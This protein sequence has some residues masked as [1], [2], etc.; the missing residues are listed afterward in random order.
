MGTTGQ[1]RSSIREES[2]TA[3]HGTTL[4]NIWVRATTPTISCGTHEG[5]TREP[6]R[7]DREA[8]TG[9]LLSQARRNRVGDLATAYV[10]THIYIDTL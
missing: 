3:G 6:E 1:H 7:E 9:G 2:G 4:E 10:H 5:E 8:G